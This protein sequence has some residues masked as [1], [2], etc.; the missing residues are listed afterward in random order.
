MEHKNVI[1]TG[2]KGKTTVAYLLDQILLRLHKNTIRVDTTGHFVNGERKSTLDE[3]KEIWSL[4]PTVC[5][6]RFLWE[7]KNFTK[8][9]RNNTVALLESSL[10]C[11][12]PCGTGLRD[13]HVG[14]WTNV[15]ADHLGSTDRLKTR[16]DIADAK[17]FVFKR[18]K[19]D[20]YAVFNACDELICKKI[21]YINKNSTLVPFV[22]DEEKIVFDC[23]KHIN[24]GGVIFYS[25]RC[26]NYQK[27]KRKRRT[28]LRFI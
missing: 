11:S 14:V 7:L 10:G 21:N 1:I 13:H 17:D 4:V 5:P 26:K 3:S 8:E 9:Q 20:G 19:D 16:E 2:T 27:D 22:V 24:E 15:M 23:K 28:L 12:N 18:I 25:E 6:G